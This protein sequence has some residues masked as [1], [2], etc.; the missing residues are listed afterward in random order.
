VKFPAIVLG[1]PYLLVLGHVPGTRAVHVT[2]PRVAQKVPAQIVV[3][4]PHRLVTVV[5]V[6]LKEGE[7]SAAFWNEVNKCEANMEPVTYADPKTRMALKEHRDNGAPVNKDSVEA[8]Q[9]DKDFHVVTIQEDLSFREAKASFDTSTL[10]VVPANMKRSSQLL[11]SWSLNPD[12]PFARGFAFQEGELMGYYL[13]GNVVPLPYLDELELHTPS[14]GVTWSRTV[15][16]A[17]KNFVFSEHGILVKDVAPF[18]PLGSGN[19]CQWLPQ[20]A[21]EGKPKV[22]PGDLIV[23]LNDVGTT[24]LNPTKQPNL[25]PVFDNGGIVDGE[26]RKQLQEVVAGLHPMEPILVQVRRGGQHG[27]EG[28]LQ[29][30]LDKQ[31]LLPL[32]PRYYGVDVYP[33]WLIVGGL[34]FTKASVPLLAELASRGDGAPVQQGILINRRMLEE[35]RSKADEEVVV[36]C[37][38][39]PHPDNQFYETRMMRAVS[40][41]NGQE[42]KN[43]KDM[44]KKVNEAW[45]APDANKFVTISFEGYSTAANLV[46]ETLPLSA[47]EK[48][49]GQDQKNV[50]RVPDLVFKTRDLIETSTQI[51]GM[52]NIPSLLS[53]SL[54]ADQAD[55]LEGGMLEE[56]FT[57]QRCTDPE[58]V[59]DAANRRQVLAEALKPRNRK[60]LAFEPS[61]WAQQAQA[62]FPMG[63]GLPNGSQLVLVTSGGPSPFGMGGMSDLL[64]FGMGG[65]PTRFR[66]AVSHIH[67][68]FGGDGGNS[69]DF[70]GAT[71]VIRGPGGVLVAPVGEPADSAMQAVNRANGV[72]W[73]V[74]G[75]RGLLGSHLEK[76]SAAEKPKDPPEKKASFIEADPDR[77]AFAAAVQIQD[78]LEGK[79]KGKTKRT[80]TEAETEKKRI[81]LH[82]VVK[83]YNTAN[84]HNYM[85]PWNLGGVYSA[86]GSGLLIK[87]DEQPDVL[88]GSKVV[89]DAEIKAAGDIA[90]VVG[91]IIVTNGHVVEDGV[92]FYVER[93]FKPG[94]DKLRARL[95]AYARDADLAFLKVIKKEDEDALFK[96]P[97]ELMKPTEITDMIPPLRTTVDVAG[98]PLGGN[99]VAVSQGQIARVNDFPFAFSIP[100]GTTN[101]PT[102]LPAAVVDAAVN[103]GN[104]GGPVFDAA[105]GKC[106]GLAFA[107]TTGAQGMN[108]VIPTVVMHMV[109]PKL[110]A[111]AYKFLKSLA[112][113]Q[114][115]LGPDVEITPGA[116]RDAGKP[117]KVGHEPTV[118]DLPLAWK[119][120]ENIGFR[121]FLGLTTGSGHD[122][123][124][125]VLV[126]SIAPLQ[127]LLST[128]GTA[129]K[130]GDILT[131]IEVSPE[132]WRSID[133]RGFVE[134]S[135]DSVN[136]PNEDA[137]PSDASAVPSQNNL[138]VQ[139]EAVVASRSC[140]GQ[141]GD[142]Q[143]CDTIRMKYR[144]STGL[145]VGGQTLGE[146]A[147]LEFKASVLAQN[148]PR[149]DNMDAH[150]SWVIVG[151]LVFTKFSI[152]LYKQFGATPPMP[153]LMQGLHNF[154]PEEPDRDVVV[155]L[156]ILPAAFNTDYDVPKLAALGKINGKPVT[157]LADVISATQEA[158]QKWS[159]TRAQDKEQG[160]HV[161][162]YLR[163]EFQE[164]GEELPKDAEAQAQ[165]AEGLQ[166]IG[167]YGLTESEKRLPDVVLRF[168]EVVDDWEKVIKQHQV[169]F[170]VDVDLIGLWCQPEAWGPY[171]PT[172]TQS[173]VCHHDEEAQIHGKGFAH[174]TALGRKAMF[175]HA[176]NKAPA[177]RATLE[178]DSAAQAQGGLL[179]AKP[180][181]KRFKV[182]A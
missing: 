10:Q 90:S 45:K 180:Q 109:L 126:R 149:F 5:K 144:P 44:A 148:A 124:N 158:W 162:D 3:E 108:F 129:L 59:Q 137:A 4:A 118:P 104:S 142:G 136:H 14:L 12:P 172:S 176:I 80:D 105:T 16:P 40:A 37:G 91:N 23:A 47:E 67:Q 110:Y 131:Q 119:P 116:C 50:A 34:M 11:N 179:E 79:D 22:L 132:D 31:P 1:Y 98:Y 165:E 57:K 35:Y 166:G 9:T 19:V 150:P 42:I 152:P 82:K 167:P 101:T 26:S 62:G 25:R 55:P 20:Y 2:H 155:L 84:T 92:D 17:L 7:A 73:T 161:D 76:S 122:A 74:V 182:M 89:E 147:V 58:W 173:P 77:A 99:A 114:A 94:T 68:V 38:T 156:D 154:H 103:P 159:A 78:K 115:A 33:E 8:M 117:L 6:E 107:S 146:E 134:I 160:N 171:P 65:M 66:P 85:R 113:C 88:A 120:A 164:L 71:R 143:G 96:M 60:T 138:R 24:K 13:D 170:P 64:P 178:V 49:S 21:L 18:G 121:E 127:R 175:T 100:G 135:G 130:H 157:K 181:L 112:E 93:T 52:Y 30:E 133:S 145:G 54:C 72:G 75:R 106:V 63:I 81:P 32:A 41:V 111:E 141:A 43:L 56:R 15:N 123:K 177:N 69:S 95:I 153:T 70:G 140:N 163:F 139:F 169:P 128:S 53:Q 125:G 27:K 97:E 51:L 28:V 36:M 102:S 87:D 174:A 46:S 29:C 39:F 86:T 48:A 83:I 168:K 61:P 151:G